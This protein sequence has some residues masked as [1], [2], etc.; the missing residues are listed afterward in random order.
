VVVL[1]S[2]GSG[3]GPVVGSR[4]HDN[5]PWGLHKILGISFVAE[6]PLASQTRLSSMEFE[7]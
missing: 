1:G 7:K 5:E 4:E 6:Y 3:W 2:P